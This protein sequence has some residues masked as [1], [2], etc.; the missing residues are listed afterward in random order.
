MSFSRYFL[1][2]LTLILLS[3]GFQSLNAQLG[4]N[5]EI[6]KPKPYENRVLKSEKTG[7]KKLSTYKRFWQNVG[8]HYNYYYNANR[9]VN[10]VIDRAKASFKDDYATLLPF[11]NY[12]LDVTARDKVQLDS[13]IYKAQTG[14]VMHDLR[15]DWADNLY[16]LWGAAY[17]LEQ[18]FDSASLMFQFI[19]YSFADKEKDGYYKYIG[20]RMDGSNAMNISTKE[21]TDLGKKLLSEPPSRNDA[22]IWQIR[23]QIQMNNLA[24][25]G[26]LIAT[27]K[28]DPNFPPRLKTELEELQALWFYQQKMWDSSATHLVNAL[29]LATNRQEKARWEYL[30]AQ[31]FERSGNTEKAQDLY[32]KSTE[33]TV[34]PVMEVYARLNMVRINKSGG[35]NYVDQNIAELLKMARKDKYEEYRDIIYF[36][37]AQMEMERGNLAS[38]QELLLKGAKY[39]S[40][41]SPA[42]NNAYLLIADLSYNQKKYQQASFFYDSIQIMQLDSAGRDRVTARKPPLSKV[43]SNLAIIARQDSLQRIAAM[44]EGERTAYINKLL[45]KLR[46]QQGLKE[47]SETL[48]GGS[49]FVS[50]DKPVDLFESQ[51]SKGEWYFY[52]G[53]LKGQGVT[54]FKQIWGNRPN[55]DNWRRFTAVNQQL[56]V[57]QINKT[58]DNQPQAT[59]LNN[60]INT[61]AG[62]N[63]GTTLSFNSLLNNLPT[64]PQKLQKSN[65]SIRMA[66]FNLGKVYLNEIEDYAS[67]IDVFEQ[68]RARFPDNNQMNEVLFNLYYAYTKSGDAAKAEQMKKLMSEKYPGSRFASIIETRKDPLAVNKKSPEMTR[69][70]EN[71]YNMYIEGRFE[72]AEAAKKQADSIYKTNYWQP[73]LLYIEA[74]Y[75]IK[76][77]NDSIA[78]RG[79][80]TLIAQNAGTPIAQKAQNVLSVLNRRR[81]IEDELN[82]LQIERPKE[83]ST[84]APTPA[85]PIAQ[86][87]PRKDSIA[88]QPHKDSVV[89]QPAVA[90]VEE[91][92]DPGPGLKKD[93]VIQTNK[94]TGITSTAPIASTAGMKDRPTLVQPKPNN[95]FMF[96]PA[97][98][99]SAMII[100]DKVDPMFVNE[101]KNA[102]NRYNQEQYYNQPLQ[103][104]VASLDSTHQL[105]LIGDFNNAQ[106]AVDYALK[107][108][109]LAPNE[110]IPW[111]KP[112]KYSLSIVTTPNLEI[113]Q[114]K[115]NLAMYRKFL[116][117]NLPGKF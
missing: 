43:V 32:E 7:D 40:G 105:M 9:K 52:N 85:P 100:L 6:K 35:E 44:P 5:P 21:K 23:T 70:Y 83:D 49:T 96:D 110:I 22:F 15:S 51:Q 77:R 38:A 73:Q 93:N 60:A 94:R 4:F 59:D 41:N 25:S 42:R 99:H 97:A 19:N 92:A 109:R 87:P 46:K 67:A 82:R 79:L 65:D 17:Y 90:K 53:S 66:L 104:T 84:A 26:S 88:I 76:Q 69:D 72:E 89:I 30:A 34:D 36:M 107:A 113:L 91:P 13:V 54:T 111:L 116:E 50:P 16:L 74:I 14:I 102:F 63:G 62:V 18:K 106:E 98:K 57:N 86:A 95:V 58:R 37:A 114:D 103:I 11:Y 45:K 33:H 27:L 64:D 3:S 47:D 80:Q 12:S 78:K 28:Q 48:T 81:E 75:N 1:Y 117:Q 108:K 56:A 24:E 39:S 71:I 55:V 112:E 115:K 31:M 101:A 29:D 20:S 2:S 61:G 8:T 68:I 10:E